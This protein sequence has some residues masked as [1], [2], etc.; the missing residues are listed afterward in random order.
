[1]TA[2]V[3]AAVA[4]LVSTLSGCFPRGPDAGVDPKPSFN[5]AD[6]SRSRRMTLM[7][8][9]ARSYLTG[10]RLE[11]SVSNLHALLV[12]VVLVGQHDDTKAFGGDKRNVSTK[13]VG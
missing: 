2:M 12:R 1:M 6:S 3:C 5:T 8:L 4:E 13:A 11:D 10:K 9:L 7:G